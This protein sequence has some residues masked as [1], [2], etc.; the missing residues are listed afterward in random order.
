MLPTPALFKA[1][2]RMIGATTTTTTDTTTTRESFQFDCNDCK[3][4]RGSD[5]GREEKDNY[6]FWT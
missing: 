2:R 3:T 1:A 5:C 4:R 6:I